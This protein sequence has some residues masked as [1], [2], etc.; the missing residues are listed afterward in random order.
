MRNRQ[1]TRG[2]DAKVRSVACRGIQNDW[3]LI[4]LL[5]IFLVLY[6]NPLNMLVS[7]YRVYNP[8]VDPVAVQALGEFPSE[9][10]SIEEAVEERIPYSYDWTVHGMPWYF[11]TTSAVVE[12]GAGDCKAR[13]IVLASIL[14]AK[15]IPYRIRS[16]PVHIW[17]DYEGKRETTLESQ[18]AAFYQQDPKTGERRFKLP[19]IPL[20]DVF[21]SS[22]RAF[23]EPMPVARKLLL[24]SGV[25]VLIGAKVLLSKTGGKVLTIVHSYGNNRGN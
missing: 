24:L 7:L 14:D 8:D 5:W 2:A 25:F 13:A 20:G 11:P 15:G 18:R 6:P 16:S 23:W 3:W 17:V 4:V 22:W 10:L 19:D 21:D 12:Q 9:A 1:S